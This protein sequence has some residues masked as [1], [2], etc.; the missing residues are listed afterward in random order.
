MNEISDELS[1][2]VEYIEQSDGNFGNALQNV[3]NG[4]QDTVAGITITGARSSSFVFTQA[5]L[6]TG[7]A[8]VVPINMDNGLTFGFLRP[9]SYETWL[10]IIAMLITYPCMI[11]VT[12]NDQGLNS[13]RTDFTFKG[14]KGLGN[15]TYDGITSFTQQGPS[16]APRT[17]LGRIYTS[18]FY[19]ASL[20]I[21]STYTANLAAFLTVEQTSATI[22]G[23][24]DLTDKRIGVLAGSGIE[25]FTRTEL[26]TGEIVSAA[27]LNEALQML[28]DGEI[29]AV[30]DETVA[31]D[32]EL[33]SAPFCNLRRL[34]EIR[35]PSGWGYPFLP[36]PQ[37]IQDAFELSAVIAGLR[38]N[39]F[40]KDLDN[41]WFVAINATAACD[42][43]S[44]EPEISGVAELGGLFFILFMVI[45]FVC[46][47]HCTVWTGRK[48]YVEHL[49]DKDPNLSISNLPWILR[50]GLDSRNDDLPMTDI[51]SPNG[52]ETMIRDT[53][54]KVIENQKGGNPENAFSR[55][56]DNY[57][58][59]D[60]VAEALRE[61]GLESSNLVIGIDFTKSNTWTGKKTFGGRNLH[62]I[63]TNIVN[64][65]QFAIK[66]ICKTLSRFDD[67]NLIPAFYF[68][69]TET[70]NTDVLPL[71]THTNGCK[72]LNDVLQK[73]EDK[74]QKVKLSGTTSFAPIINKTI[75][76]VKMKKS[77]HILLI[78]GD[79]AVTE[80]DDRR[81]T[82]DAII[83]ASRYPLSIVMIGVGDGP[84]DEM[85]KYDNELPK[86]KFDNFQFVP[87]LDTE[88]AFAVNAL[89]EI[90]DQYRKIKELGYI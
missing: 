46:I 34:K 50:T 29:D 88:T 6:Q 48:K 9:F 24:N 39:G 76:I 80:V 22:N 35:N 40:T 38:D 83:R 47:A 86:R 30:V 20:I 74:V 70:N 5:Y 78:I 4:D 58:T 17:F 7:F 41:T 18:M 66:T 69:D 33:L 68:G 84:W 27:S 77:Y 15:A 37:R 13:G 25:T 32:F 2:N 62:T 26:S 14:R 85:I 11:Y 21:I 75:E 16:S 71:H 61:S 56:F 19:F 90:P 42:S 49:L 36:T 10:L 44:E 52:I 28:V 67:D 54:L 79:G 43:D 57:P 72:G 51:K 1:F 63:D 82:Q 81:A 59:L 73:Y 89:Q 53:C 3:L 8:L 55:I 45:I 31:I 23:F 12:E 65:Y 64:P 87:P 60:K